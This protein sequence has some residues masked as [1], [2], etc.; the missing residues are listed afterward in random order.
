MAD[1]NTLRRDQLRRNQLEKSGWF[2]SERLEAD[3]RIEPCS[4]KPS[5]LL[6]ADGGDAACAAHDDVPRA[7]I[8]GGGA[9]EIAGLDRPLRDAAAAE[10]SAFTIDL[11]RPDRHAAG[12]R[13]V[14]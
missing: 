9:A 6:S 4:R 1:R 10:Q 8:D 13:F 3:R 14:M 2:S 11:E 5:R 7:C 12:L